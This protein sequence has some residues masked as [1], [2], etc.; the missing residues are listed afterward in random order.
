MEPANPFPNY[1]QMRQ[2]VPIPIWHSLR[3]VSVGVALGLCLVLIVRPVL[4]LWLFW[5]VLIPLLPLL[6]FLAPGLWRNL[7]PLAAMNQTPRLFQLSRALTLPR[8]LQDYGYVVAITLFLLIV[9]ARKL[10]FNTN[11]VATALLI[12]GVLAAAFV[13]GTLF[14]GKSGW[15]SSICPLLPVQRV[16]GQTPFLTVPNSHCQPCV[17]CTKNCYD[18]N[19]RVAYLA[20]LHDADRHV[21]A[22]RKFFVGLFPGFILAFY[23]LPNAPAISPFRLYGQMGLYALVSVALFF[24]ADSLVKT[25][26]NKITVLFG[27]A[28]LN[29][30]YWFNAITISRLIANP[31]PVGVVWSLR[32][33]VLALTL[34]WIYRTYQKEQTFIELVL[35]PQHHE[36]DATKDSQVS[37]HASPE[38]WIE[39]KRIA[40]EPGKTLL[41]IIEAAGLPI[42]AGCR[43]GVCGADPVCIVKGMDQLSKVSSEERTT[44][45]RLGRGEQTRMACVTR[46]RGTVEVSLKAEPPKKFTSSVIAG[47]PYDKTIKRVVIV[48][49]GIAGVTAADHV[50]RRHPTCEIHLIGR[51]RH[52]LYNR[53]GITRLIYGRSAMSG[54]YLLPEKWYDDYAITTWL[55]THVTGIDPTVRTVSLG[56]GETLDY[57]RLILTT[58][59]QSYVPPIAGYGLPGSFVLRAADDAMAIRAFVQEH[60]CRHGVVAGGGLLGLEAAYGLHKLGLR[61]AVLERSLALL[62]RQLDEAGAHCLRQHLEQVGLHIV[63]EAETATIDGQGRVQA[64]TL[65]DGRTL[66][67]DLFLVA[68]G[69]RSEVALATGLGLTVNRGV[70]VDGHMRTSDPAIFAAGDVAEFNGQTLGLWPVAV[71]QAETA[72]ANAVASLHTTLATYRDLVPVT[73]LKVVGVDLTSIGR[74]EAQS[75][76]ESE[77]VFAESA[78]H[79]YRKLVIADG[80]VVG[81]ILLGYPALAPAI[82]EISKQ[83]LEISSHLPALRNGDWDVLKTLVE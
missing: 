44:L 6:F 66:P 81:A 37:R 21:A 67:C 9:P 51:E 82:A 31:A 14:K 72:A 26:S 54:L 23:T 39:G 43:M 38:V 5:Q 15:C 76:D 11:G 60:G 30:Y 12:L 2:W 83:G 53:M 45:E 78:Q 29:L 56:T 22:S 33:V 34:L 57:D 65:T 63:T 7:C 59:S 28:A 58:G 25:T 4:G 10:L 19:P 13:M 42:E 71:S 1:L 61:V 24:A 46:V 64:V 52:H 50:R 3:L 75:E 79:R 36:G 55:N 40:L 70:V 69:I 48:G 17:G 47:Y 77:I 68:A 16:Y 41:E 20:D 35:A 74:I 80:K 8:W 73:M 49:N 32:I 62:R 27:A 18:F